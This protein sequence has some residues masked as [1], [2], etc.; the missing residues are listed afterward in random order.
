LGTLTYTEL[1]TYTKVQV[2]DNAAWSS[3]TDYY[4][5]WVNRA[6]QRLTTQDKFWGLRQ[7]FYFPQLETSSSADTVDGTAYVSVPSTA[8]VIRDVYD[9]ENYRLLNN[10]THHKYL[11][12]LDRADTTAEGAPVEW[13]R[14]ASYI[15]LHPTPDDAY[16]LTIHYRKI[17]TALSAGSDTTAIGPEWDEPII[18]LAAHIGKMWTM[19]YEHAKLLK[20]EFL[21][22]VAGIITIYN[23][24]ARSRKE[25][26]YLDE[27]YR[28]RS[29]R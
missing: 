28:D 14:S 11:G 19:D 12:Y 25:H 27:T 3:P 9:T 20:E 5:I 24:E 16:T 2:G 23:S 8:L 1:A 6:Y 13:V 17:P 10:I 22:Q 26:I 7:S 15:Y 4:A 18:T 21:E 29:Y